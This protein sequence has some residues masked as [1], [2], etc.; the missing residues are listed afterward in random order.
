MM[1]PGSWG[2]SD[3]DLIAAPRHDGLNDPKLFQTIGA[4]H[5][6]TTAKLGEAAENWRDP[7]KKF[8]APWLGLILGGSTHQRTINNDMGR[9]LGRQV[10]RM[11]ADMGGSLLIT[12]SPRTRDLIDSVANG[13][14]EEG[15]PPAYIYHWDADGENPYLGFLALA[16]VLVVTGDSVSMCTEA[17]AVSKPVY[18]YAPLGFAVDKHRLLHEELYQAGY[19]RPLDSETLAGGYETWTHPSLNPAQIV[20]DEIRKRMKG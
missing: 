6:V 9:E 18:I 11:A 4:P 19:A 2:R 12:T 10:G 20:A 1:Y 8:T 7:F 16:D 13:A 17:C 14:E 3:F 15:T 5:R